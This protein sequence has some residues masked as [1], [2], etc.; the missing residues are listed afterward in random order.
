VP[1]WKKDATEFTVGVNHNKVRGYQA[2][3]PKPIMDKLHDPQK[4]TFVIR[5]KKVEVEAA[6]PDGSA[7]DK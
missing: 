2:S 4:I 3:I 7:D 6:R 1:R 5:G